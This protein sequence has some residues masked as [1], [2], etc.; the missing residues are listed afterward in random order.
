QLFAR[1][2]PWMGIRSYQLWTRKEQK[3]CIALRVELFSQISVSE[4]KLGQNKFT[5]LAQQYDVGRPVRAAGKRAVELDEAFVNR[6]TDS[7]DGVDDLESSRVRA[8]ESG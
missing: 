8:R 7:L 5:R 1:P 4:L 6:L 2:G 3:L